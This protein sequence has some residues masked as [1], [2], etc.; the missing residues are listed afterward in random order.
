MTA[1]MKRQATAPAFKAFGQMLTCADIDW[2]SHF[3][4]TSLQSKPGVRRGA[5]VAV[6]MSKLLAFP[7]AMLGIIH[8]EAGS[9]KRSCSPPYPYASPRIRPE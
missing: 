8:L 3:F 2:L 1:A 6:M 7:I 4:A 9:C 5:R